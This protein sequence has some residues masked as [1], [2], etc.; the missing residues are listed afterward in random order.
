LHEGPAI[1]PGLRRSGNRFDLHVM[2]NRCYGA[3]RSEYVRMTGYDMLVRKLLAGIAA[4]AIVLTGLTVTASATAGEWGDALPVPGLAALNLGNYVDVFSVS[5]TSPGNCSAVGRYNDGS[6]QQGFLVD[7]V[8]G[9]WQQ[10]VPVPGLG[11]LDVGRNSAVREVSCSSDGNCSAVGNYNDGSGLASAFV[12]DRVG[13][14]WQNAVPIPGVAALAIGQYGLASSVSCT[15]DGNCSALGQ[16][17]DGS[18]NFQLFVV[19]RVAGVW[20]DAIPVPGLIALNQNGQAESGGISCSSDGN[21]SAGGSYSATSGNQG[22]VV[23]R[24]SG[25]WQTAAPIPGLEALNVANVAAVNDLSCSSTGNCSAVG[26][27]RNGSGDQGFVV[28]RVAGVWQ[29][30]IAAPGLASLGTRGEVWAL[31]CPL[32]GD[33]SAVGIAVVGDLFAVTIDR[34]GG[35]WQSAQAIPGLADLGPASGVSGI[36]C[37]NALNCSMTG[38]YN[39]GSGYEGFVVDRVGGV[40]QSAAPIAG[41]AGLN[42]GHDAQG[43]SISCAAGGACSVGGNFES[44][45]GRQGFVVDRQL[46]PEPTT[47]TTSPSLDPT[48]PVFTG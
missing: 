22:F 15:S 4:L 14:V 34:I 9:A 48:V 43:T 44:G 6:A 35:V 39:P 17:M 11:A 18:S 7:R 38:S 23:D 16:Y 46:P 42:T 40:W 20:Q 12:V 29:S 2:R 21:C 8:G 25:V 19:D 36:S 32:D 45:G 1:A 31:S 10:A 3:I 24:V 41:L 5:C 28:D 33:C 27:F 30:A 13:G 47:T 26:K 37:W